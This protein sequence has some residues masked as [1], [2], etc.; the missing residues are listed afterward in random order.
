MKS[1]EL[2]HHGVK[3]MKWGVRRYQNKDG[4]LTDKGIKR[5]AKK[6]YAKDA[7]NANKSV[8]GKIY[9][10]YTG[11]HKISAEYKYASS[12]K[13][14]NEAMAKKYLKDKQAPINKK[15]G[16][17]LIKGVEK[18]REKAEKHNESI[19]RTTDRFGVGGVALSSY[20]KYQS[21]R[22]SKA[23]LANVVNSAANAYISSSSGSYYSKR[24]ADFARRAVISGLS[25][26]SYSDLVRAYSDVGKSAIYASSKKR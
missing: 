20:M 4:S 25:I 13:K 10:A 2:Y 18:S 1:N 24:G 23:I 19:K 22:S 9:D 15:V 14:K 21:K 12:S 17:A 3:G 7:F 11:A 8:G 6:G 26:S 16:K 5:Y